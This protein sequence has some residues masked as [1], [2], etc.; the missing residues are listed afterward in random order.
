MF[1]MSFFSEIPVLS[2]RGGFAALRPLPALPDACRA[3]F[4][5]PAACRAPRR[6]NLY[7]FTYFTLQNKEMQWVRDN[8]PADVDVRRRSA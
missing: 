8:R 1:F 4:W 5:T 7:Y 6:N 2:P 3:P